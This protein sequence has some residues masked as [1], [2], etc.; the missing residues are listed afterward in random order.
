MSKDNI[1]KFPTKSVDGG[2]AAE[3]T[4]DA[5]KATPE[6]DAVKTAAEPKSAEAKIKD[7]LANKNY[8]IIDVKTLECVANVQ[9][10]VTMLMVINA[11]SCTKDVYNDYTIRSEINKLKAQ[12]FAALNSKTDEVPADGTKK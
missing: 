4:A 3:I 11:L 6:K 2:K 7:I 8:I 5:P 9:P 1:T 12:I 10:D